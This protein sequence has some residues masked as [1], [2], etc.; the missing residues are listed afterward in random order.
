MTW[1]SKLFGG[2]QEDEALC[3][4]VPQAICCA[5]SWTVKYRQETRIAVQKIRPGTDH[6]QAQA[7][8]DGEWQPL[9]MKWTKRG[10]VTCPGNKH[11][12][13]EPYRY[14]TLREWVEDQIRYTDLR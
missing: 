6:C 4:C 13:V 1:L 14:V 8:I 2:I 12:D 10:P 3:Y 5:W 7:L 11:F 9:I